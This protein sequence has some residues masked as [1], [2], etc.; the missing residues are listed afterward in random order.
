MDA[1]VALIAKSVV[2]TAS[3]AAWTTSPVP[4]YPEPYG[5]G[6]LDRV[7]LA[8]SHRGTRFEMTR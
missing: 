3:T 4:V 7:E 1:P 2:S 5:A 8:E 6:L